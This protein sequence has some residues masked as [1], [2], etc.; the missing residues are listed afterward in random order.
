MTNEKTFGT[1]LPVYLD[2]SDRGLYARIEGKIY[3]I[4]RRYKDVLTHTGLAYCFITRDMSNYGFIG[5]S[6]EYD[7][8][9]DLGKIFESIRCDVYEIDIYLYNGVP[10]VYL[11][12]RASDNEGSIYYCIGNRG[13]VGKMNYRDW[14][15]YT[16]YNERVN[17]FFKNNC[18]KITLEYVLNHADDLCNVSVDAVIKMI[19]DSVHTGYG[20]KYVKVIDSKI[21][22]IGYYTDVYYAVISGKYVRLHMSSAE[23]NAG[24][25][26]D[27]T[28]KVCD[29]IR[30]H[31]IT[32]NHYIEDN[33]GLVVYNKRFLNA[34]SS[35][36]MIPIHMYSDEFYNTHKDKVEQ[37]I[38]EYKEWVK[39]L[40]KY[41]TASTAR[42]YLD[43]N[44]DKLYLEPAGVCCD[45]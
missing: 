5:G 30:S 28:D 19:K 33:D 12:D 27:I 14:Y 43:L 11:Y 40:K 15:R 13:S 41:V 36:Y 9:F 38:K 44:I 37:S 45:V 25:V 20:A 17:S 29:F 26:V 42:D 21:V 23:F 24:N 16:C 10:F 39:G 7:G 35:V 8:T 34:T 32:Y 1:V 2:R 4:D 3:F 31:G 22:S 6:Y 18:E